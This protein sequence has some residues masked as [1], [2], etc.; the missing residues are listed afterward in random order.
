MFGIRVETSPRIRVNSFEGMGIRGGI[1]PYLF[2]HPTSSWMISLTLLHETA[3]FYPHSPSARMSRV[4]SLL[5]FHLVGVVAVECHH[6]RASTC[7][8]DALATT[9]RARIESRC[10][11]FKS[12]NKR[13]K[14][15]LARV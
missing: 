10:P 11:L 12:N 4:V 15:E 2:P 5:L 13:G 9:K 1:K 6:P 7:V 14:V 3:A 8:L